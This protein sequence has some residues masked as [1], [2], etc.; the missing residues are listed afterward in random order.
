MTDPQLPPPGAVPSEPSASPAPPVASAPPVGSSAPTQPAAPPAFVAPPAYPGAAPAA[1]VAPPYAGTQPAPQAYAVPQPQAAPPGAYQVPVGGY[2]APSGSYVAPAPEPQKGGAFGVIALVLGLLAAV[3]APIAAGVLGFEIGTR[4]PSGLDAGDP[5]F[6]R[7][8]S[9][10]R[11]QVLWAEITFWTATVAG[12]AAIVTGILAIR[13][14]QRRG[15]GVTGLVIAIVGPIVFWV[16]M[17][18]TVSIGT[19]TG[20]AR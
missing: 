16:V 7:A 13:S 5:D 4:I 6:L 12:I 20:F 15:L 11:T 19:A 17:L 8:L 18:F 14:K 3:V 9:P 10:A 1:P 2:A